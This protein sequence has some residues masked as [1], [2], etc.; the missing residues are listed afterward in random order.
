[1]KRFNGKKIVRRRNELSMLQE[2]LAVSIKKSV[3]AVDRFEHNK[4]EPKANTID[5]ACEGFEV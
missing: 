4:T 3:S 5:G 2:E 1:M